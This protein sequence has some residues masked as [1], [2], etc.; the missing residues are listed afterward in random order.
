M[1]RLYYLLRVVKWIP[2][3]GYFRHLLPSSLRNR[4]ESLTSPMGKSLVTEL[5]EMDDGYLDM[6][7]THR[8]HRLD[9]AIK[10]Q[11]DSIYV[12]FKTQLEAA[13][14]ESQ[15]RSRTGEHISW[16]ETTLARYREWEKDKKRTIN[17]KTDS[18]EQQSDDIYN[19]IKNRRSIRYFTLRDIDKE[20]LELIL[21]AGRWAP[22]SG[23]RQ[24][25]HFIVQKLGKGNKKNDDTK[26]QAVPYGAILIYIAM[27]QR[28]YPWKH[29]A[30]MDAAA[31]I[32]NMI[33]LAHH[34]GIGSCWY[35]GAE[36]L[37]Q[38]K[39]RAKFKLPDYYTIYST[40]QFG[41]PA[42]I[43]E[44]PGRKPLSSMTTYAGFSDHEKETIIDGKP[45]GIND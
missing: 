12:E 32:Q 24:A 42:E 4:F 18:T 39:L 30:A 45:L 15:K 16:A 19:V 35:Y 9:K 13:L 21:E 40:V 11:S 26:T 2:F 23:N 25:W 22:C 29:A 8:S 5:S 37:D 17:L 6:I 1:S 34:L 38:T 44:V 27:D 28:L 43:P 41:Y 10:G 3:H 14:E 31:A 7:I 20:N 36:R 33:L